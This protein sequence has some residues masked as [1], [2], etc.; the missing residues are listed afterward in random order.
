M[1]TLRSSQSFTAQR[2]NSLKYKISA[3]GN[4]AAVFVY[5]GIETRFCCDKILTKRII[6]SVV[7]KK[8]PFFVKLHKEG[9]FIRR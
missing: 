5:Y 4:T 7:N 3:V 1:L 6:Q 8:C 9:G 2:N